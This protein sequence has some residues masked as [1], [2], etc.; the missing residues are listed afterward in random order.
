INNG[1]ANIVIGTRSAIFAPFKRLGLIIVEDEEDMSYKQEQKPMYQVNEVAAR[2]AGFNQAAVILGSSSPSVESYWRGQTGRYELI[3][4]PRPVD[5][6]ALPAVKI[7]DI[8]E[9][10]LRK[11]RGPFYRKLKEAII[12]RL[13]KGEQTVIF[14]NR[15]GWANFVV[16]QKCGLVLKCPNCDVSLS[17]HLDV[18]QLECHY[19]GYKQRMTDPN[20]LCPACKD[21]L[22]SYLGK[23]TQ[24]IE[25]QLAKLF[26]QIKIIRLDLDTV[27]KETPET[28]IN[29][30]NKGKADVLIATQIILRTG[31]LP[32][33]SLL[34][35]VLADTVLN[36]PDFHS[37]EHAYALFTRLVNLIRKNNL[38][39]EVI[40]QTYNPSHYVMTAIKAHNYR[41]FYDEEINFRKELNYPPFG[42]MINIIVKGKEEKK[43]ATAAGELGEAFKTT[44]SRSKS[45]VSV[46]GPAPAPLVKLR[47]FYRW[48]ILLKGE[49]ADLMREAVRRVL[50]DEKLPRGLKVSLDVDPLDIS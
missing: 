3:E 9:E 37:A 6:K 15:R 10:I 30:F 42:H 45:K 27:K 25:N 23:G 18:K 20:N 19:C 4:L 31:F 12:Q 7:V 39:A 17:Y 41:G 50:A 21:P 2:R 46:L 49:D 32:R 34:G 47:S 28:I 29:K 38:P 22:I 14:L 1:Q 13:E 11:N 16:C 5:G 44:F 33:V 48:Q 36:I 40:I 43:V 8:K 26:P 24:R 35:V